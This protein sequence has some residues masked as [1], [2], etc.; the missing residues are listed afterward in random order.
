[1]VMC[2]VQIH[3]RIGFV[4][5]QHC[6]LQCMGSH[7]FQLAVDSQGQQHLSLSGHETKYLM[8]WPSGTWLFPLASKLKITVLIVAIFV[9]TLSRILVQGPRCQLACWSH[10]TVIPVLVNENLRALVA[11][12][13]QLR[14]SSNCQLPFV[15]WECFPAGLEPAAGLLVLRAPR[16]RTTFSQTHCQFPRC[17]QWAV[18]EAS[19]ASSSCVKHLQAHRAHSNLCLAGRLTRDSNSCGDHCLLS[20]L[21][22]PWA[23]HRIIMPFNDVEASHWEDSLAQRGTWY[24]KFVFSVINLSVITTASPGEIPKKLWNA[25]NL[26]ALQFYQN[27]FTIG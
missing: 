13:Q 16:C 14:P 3:C 5:V 22:I 6:F 27:W 21:L 23:S 1:M 2:S 26:D 17:L 19:L 20:S 9:S 4:N 15:H 18:C 10:R 24:F 25:E 8:T 11:V 12:V 7:F